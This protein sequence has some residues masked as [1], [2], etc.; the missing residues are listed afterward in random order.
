MNDSLVLT[1]QEMAQ[2]DAYTIETLKLTDYTLMRQAATGLFDYAMQHRLIPQTQISI[3]VGLGNNGGDGVVFGEHLVNKGYDV[4]LFVIGDTTKHSP[5]LKKALSECKNKTTIYSIHAIADLKHRYK[6]L[7]SSELI[8]DALFGTG[9]KMPLKGIF[10]TLVDEINTFNL[11]VISIDIPSGINAYNGLA[12]GSAIHA[13]HTFII[14]H[15]KTGNLLHDAADY[16]GKHHVIDVGIHMPK[17]AYNRVMPKAQISLKSHLNNTHKYQRGV[18]LLIGGSASMEGAL[19]MAS[20]AALKSG[21]GLVYSLF[22]NAKCYHKTVPLEILTHH[23]SNPTDVLDHLDR[24]DVI[25]F[26]AGLE[27][28]RS[29]YKAVLKKLIDT[30]KPLLID[31]GGLYYFK[32]IYEEFDDL[33]NVLITPHVGELAMMGNQTTHSVLNDPLSAIK[34]F[35]SKQATVLLKGPC[36]I[37]ATHDTQI[38]L[39]A[40]NPALAKGGSGDILGGLILGFM[41]HEPLLDAAKNGALL[42]THSTIAAL[43]DSVEE[44]FIPSDILK[45]LPKGINMLK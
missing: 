4:T 22:D 5:S 17:F 29:D 24:K 23:L 14:Q 11:P 40:P 19:I 31:A 36:S 9:L 35:T 6:S 42:H 41:K 25:L 45:Y 20:S 32:A 34:P 30:K 12:L 43:N 44:T 16:H 8:I 21:L 2:S 26:G 15:Y 39:Y 13:T 10:K 3:L 7:Q 28:N 27:T 1:P 33:S 18:A 37:I 38:Y